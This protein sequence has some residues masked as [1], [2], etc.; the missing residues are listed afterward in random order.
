LPLTRARQNGLTLLEVLVVITLISMISTVLFQ[1]YAY[2]MGNYQRLRDRQQDEFH[3]ALIS[4]WWRSSLES[5]VPYHE[6]EL[7]FGGTATL[8][9]GASFSPL[10]GVPGVPGE[11]SWRL[12]SKDDTLQLLYEEPPQASVIVEEW[13]LGAAGRFEYLS[14]SGV[15]LSD[16]ET[17]VERQIPEAIRLVVTKPDLPAEAQVVTAVIPIRK[18]QEIP[19][20]V[21]LYGHE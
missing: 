2:M 5:L 18:S 10:W 16:W 8:M 19:S 9:H 6:H 3:A 4:G 11:I 15:W 7:R 1:G 17:G 21:V 13:A 20:S 14:E 12:D